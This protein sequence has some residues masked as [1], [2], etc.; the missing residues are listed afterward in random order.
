MSRIRL[1]N[2]H[3]LTVSGARAKN[4]GVA[5][6]HVVQTVFSI[7][8]RDVIAIVGPN[9]CA[10]RLLLTWRSNIQFYAAS[11]CS[12]RSQVAA[13]TA[14]VAKLYREKTHGSEPCYSNTWTRRKQ[15]RPALNQKL[16]RRAVEAASVL[17]SNFAGVLFFG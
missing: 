4:E 1:N 9:T 5:D 10:L 14:A 8:E 17:F 2:I 16:Y 7:R 6:E 11:V 3:S 15:G 12:A 13:K